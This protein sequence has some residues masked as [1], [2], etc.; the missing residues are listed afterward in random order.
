MHLTTWQQKGTLSTYGQSLEMRKIP[1]YQD[2]VF[3][4]VYMIGTLGEI[5]DQPVR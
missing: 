1:L 3:N 4:A 5:P 2:A